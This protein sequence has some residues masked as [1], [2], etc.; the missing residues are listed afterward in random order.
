M[1]TFPWISLYKV[2]FHCSTWKS[3]ELRFSVRDSNSCLLFRRKPRIVSR[4]CSG[5][6]YDIRIG[7]GMASLQILMGVSRMAHYRETLHREQESRYKAWRKIQNTH[8]SLK[9]SLFE[10]PS[11]KG[12]SLEVI[13]LL[14]DYFSSTG[15]YTTIFPLGNLLLTSSK[16]RDK[17]IAGRVLRTKWKLSP[18]YNCSVAFEQS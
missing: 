1:E 7:K 8:K 11:L 14:R 9:A 2:R 6:Y 18:S 4:M 16:N 12:C 10:S 5:S 17:F 15:I 3:T 13:L